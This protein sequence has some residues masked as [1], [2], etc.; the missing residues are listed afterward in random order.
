MLPAQQRFGPDDASFAVELELEVQH[1][2]AA[3]DRVAQFGLHRRACLERR[4]CCGI[5][6]ARR[7][8]SRRLGLVHRHVGTPQQL[9]RRHL[10]A[11]EGADADAGGGNEVVHPAPVPCLQCVG[12]HQRRLDLAGDCLG[13]RGGRNFLGVEVLQQDDK[14]VAAQPRH[15]VAFAKAALQPLGHFDQQQVAHVVAVGVVER[16][17]VVQVQEHHR[18]VAAPA[19]AAD[20]RVAQA[21]EQQAPVRQ[22]GQRIVEREGADL[23]LRFLTQGDIAE[24]PD[25]PHD[26]VAQA[27]R[28]GVTLEHAA[29]A[30]L[31]LVVGNL[32]GLPVELDHLLHELLRVRQLPGHEV[33]QALVVA[34]VPQFCGDPPQVDKALVEGRKLAGRIHHQDAVGR[35]LDCRVQQRDGPGH[36]GSRVLA[37]AREEQAAADDEQG[38]GPGGGQQQEQVQALLLELGEAGQP[39]DDVDRDPVSLDRAL[40]H[41]H[42]QALPWQAQ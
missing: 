12:L 34:H 4:L 9:V 10:L 16:L 33:E 6:E 25:P 21:V 26:L 36:L 17:E 22:H 35:G 30:K 7:V 14:L 38:G 23:P 13:V 20:H 39:I 42:G 27:L 24:V 15:G 29:V 1:Q 18:R 5:E 2:L 3:C 41:Q 40:R 31:Q 8:A 11:Q 19:V 28:I 32:L 37:K